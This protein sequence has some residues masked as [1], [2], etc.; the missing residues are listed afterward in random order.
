M[1]IPLLD[2]NAQNLPLERELKEAFDRVL[3]SGK[4]IM[5]PDVQAFEQE[6]AEML[7][8][9]HAIGVS[10]G[11]DAL[12]LSLMTLGIGPG[13]EVICPTLTFFSTAGCISRVGATPIFV[14]VCPACF[15]LRPDD[16]RTK[17]TSKTKAIIPVHL[18][19]QSAAMDEILT[20]AKE[21]KLDVIEDV[22]QAIGAKY[23]DHYCGTFGDFGTYSFFPS[24]NLGGLGDGGIVVT[25]D[26]ELA[27]KARILR[28]HGSNP[29]YY[30]AAIG[31]NF[32]LD[33]LQAALLRVKLKYLKQYTHQ[34]KQNARYYTEKL[35]SLPSITSSSLQSCP[36]ISATDTPNDHTTLI[37]PKQ[38]PHCEHVWNQYTIRILGNGNRDELKTLLNDNNIGCE[39]YYPLC[40]HQQECFKDIVTSEVHSHSEQ[41]ANQVLS[42][43][44]YPE[45]KADMQDRIIE[46]VKEWIS[47][48]YQI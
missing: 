43:P 45:L 25:S 18:F 5:G 31:G 10:S 11:T 35:S 30:H 20:I 40:L 15:N 7:G 44:I 27:S 23:R 14:D 28:N 36:P 42:L 24:K 37:L 8:V 2:V 16:V 33:T 12:L 29:K 47:K 21:H 38:M 34:R 48:K 1:N 22:A 17:I 19:G 32:R 4:F 41:L 26:S 46:L 6:V 9:P 3:Q 39:I 13:D